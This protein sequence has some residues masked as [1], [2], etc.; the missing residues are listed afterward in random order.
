MS[1][2]I[3]D[4]GHQ[5]C[6]S[7]TVQGAKNAVLPIFAGCVLTKE[8]VVIKNVP[9]LADVVSMENILKNLG[10]VSSLA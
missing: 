7:I 6:G 3:I 1:K 8:E 10:L 2:Y 4:G 5:L 9:D